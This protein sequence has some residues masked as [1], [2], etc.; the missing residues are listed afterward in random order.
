MKAISAGALGGVIGGAVM[1]V[2][3][4]IGAR[5]G[6]MHR[7]LAEN[8]EDWLERKAG[9]RELVGDAGTT[10]IEQTNHLAASAMFGSGYAMARDYLPGLPSPVLG[11]LYGTGLYLVN[12]AGIA[13]LLGLTKGEQNASMGLRSERLGMHVLY[14][15]VTAIAVDTLTRAE[16]RHPE[17]L[18]DR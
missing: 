17:R 2:A 13:P 3:M 4:A 9:T 10:A 15:I 1:S 14:G 11:A 8:A 18:F 7:T 5:T 12:I 16:R 6:L